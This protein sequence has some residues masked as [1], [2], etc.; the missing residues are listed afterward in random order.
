MLTLPT[1]TQEQIAYYYDKFVDLKWELDLKRRSPT[2]YKL[3]SVLRR[4]YAR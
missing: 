4:A 2:K 3:Y 1:L